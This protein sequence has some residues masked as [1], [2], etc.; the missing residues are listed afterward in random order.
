MENKIPIAAMLSVR[1]RFAERAADMAQEIAEELK[2]PMF[3]KKEERA[4]YEAAM[5]DVRAA[6]ARQSALANAAANEIL[7]AVGFRGAY[8]RRGRR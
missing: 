4:E 5:D 7:A 6:R 2:P 1:A 3:A 8:F